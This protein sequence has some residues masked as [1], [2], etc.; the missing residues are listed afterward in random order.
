MWGFLFDFVVFW[1]I[2][3]LKA[4]FCVPKIQ[5]HIWFILFFPSAIQYEIC[6]LFSCKRKKRTIECVCH[7]FFF[8][9]SGKIILKT[10]GY[11]NQHNNPQTR[12]LEKWQTNFIDMNTVHPKNRITGFS[13]H[14]PKELSYGYLRFEVNGKIPSN[15]R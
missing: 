9:F 3:N 14:F 1:N 12:K 7:S 6:I 15:L 13:L 2:W 11:E 10:H 4:I 8:L 5:Y